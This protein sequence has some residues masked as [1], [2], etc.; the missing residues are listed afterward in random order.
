MRDGC[1]AG[2]SRGAG[3]VACAQCPE[4]PRARKEN[5]STEK[6][7][8]SE[9]VLRQLGNVIFR[10]QWL[11]VTVLL[12]LS[13]AGQDVTFTRHIAPILF[14]HCAECHRPGQSAPFPLVTYADAKKH[15]ADI[16]KV[17]ASGY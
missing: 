2:R 9:T 8:S 12:G 4:E 17:A 5:F 13:S 7:L 3:F 11:L 14:Q 6:Q 16:V 10:A 1:S 15:A